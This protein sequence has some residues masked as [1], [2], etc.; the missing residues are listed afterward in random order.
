MTVE[1]SDSAIDDLLAI[2]AYLAEFS[3]RAAYEF[4][5]AYEKALDQIRA[6][7]EIGQLSNGDTA[8]V[9]RFGVYRFV[10]RVNDDHAILGRIIDGRSQATLP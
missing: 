6:F 1:V 10:Y 8:R 3:E 7:P 5:E 9:L 2:T 4:I